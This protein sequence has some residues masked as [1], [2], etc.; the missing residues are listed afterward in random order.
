MSPHSVCCEETCSLERWC[1]SLLYCSRLNQDTRFVPC[2]LGAG[3]QEATQR[4]FNDSAKLPDNGWELPS[5]SSCNT[6]V[7]TAE[8][9]KAGSASKDTLLIPRPPNLMGRLTC[10][11]CESGRVLLVMPDRADLNRSSNLWGSGA[12]TE[13]EHRGRC[14]ILGSLKEARKRINASWELT[15]RSLSTALDNTEHLSDQ[16]SFKTLHGN[17]GAPNKVASLGSMRMNEP[18][19][20][21]PQR[22]QDEP[23]TLT[24]PRSKR[25]PS[26][27]QAAWSTHI[28][29]Y[30]FDIAD[31]S[32]VVQVAEF[33]VTS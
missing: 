12:S 15:R 20:G 9:K 26:W 23:L 1:S 5:I 21:H 28:L 29:S 33:Q 24:L 11:C 25:A 3:P 8:A 17:R 27:S 32:E 13:G 2:W 31:Q 14:W 6:R 19:R 4:L 10:R 18:V 16:K 7:L 30:S 22:D